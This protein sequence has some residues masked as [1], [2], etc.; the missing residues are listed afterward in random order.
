MKMKE[1]LNLPKTEFPQ[2]ANLPKR[3]PGWIADR[4]N[5]YGQIQEARKDA[6][7]YVLHDGPPYANGDAHIGTG[8]NKVLKDIVVRYKTMRGYL[9]P[10]IPGWDCHG[11]PIEHMVMRELGAEQKD[12][13]VTE[14]RRRCRIY[15][16]K[17]VDIQRGQFQRIGV[18]G[19]WENP[20]LTF[21]PSYEAGVLAVFEDLVRGGYVYRALRPIHWCISCR[22]ALAEA[23]LEYHDI[24]SPR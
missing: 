4:E 14:I 22:T 15:A 19:D 23:E 1:T 21:Q 10:Y 2:R 16:E 8:V 7:L 13:S 18:L 24:T 11:L 9:A 12:A 17:Y 3:E 6:E 20:Y 5:L